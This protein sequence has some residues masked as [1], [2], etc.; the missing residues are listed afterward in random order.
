MSCYGV[1]YILRHQNCQPQSCPL[2]PDASVH[3][4]HRFLTIAKSNDA[5]RHW[6]TEG[7]IARL[8]DSTET[9]SLSCGT[10]TGYDD[11]RD[12]VYSRRITGGPTYRTLVL[13]SA[14]RLFS[15]PNED[16]R[17]Q[18]SANEV[19]L[20]LFP[21]DHHDDWADTRMTVSVFQSMWQTHK[22]HVYS[23]IES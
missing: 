20:L 15:S 3:F 21:M 12:S 1:W 16:E 6:L 22:E 7:D 11:I 2:D 18:E 9:R 14:W 8:L 4:I 10:W 5:L 23:W 13:S 17:A 19:D